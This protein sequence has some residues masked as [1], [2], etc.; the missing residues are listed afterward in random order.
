MMND[1]APQKRSN[2]DE[3]Y[4]IIL[5]NPTPEQLIQAGFS[6][7]A[8]LSEHFCKEQGAAYKDIP[9]TNIVF[10]Q[11]KEFKQFLAENENLYKEGDDR[12]QFAK[13][14]AEKFLNEQLKDYAGKNNYLE[15]N[16]LRCHQGAFID[17]AHEFLSRG[18]PLNMFNPTTHYLRLDIDKNIQST[19]VIVDAKTI[20]ANDKQ[21]SC[22]DMGLIQSIDGSPL[23]RI[24][25]T[26]QTNL[27][28]KSEKTTLLEINILNEEIK[29]L[30]FQHIEFGTDRITLENIIKQHISLEDNEHLKIVITEANKLFSIY[31]DGNDTQE[32]HQS[33]YLKMIL[34]ALKEHTFSDDKNNLIVSSIINSLHD[35]IANKKINT[36]T[37]AQLYEY[38]I[39]LNIQTVLT[40]DELAKYEKLYNDEKKSTTQEKITAVLSSCYSWF[41]IYGF[42]KITNNE[43]VTNLINS[44]TDKY[45]PQGE[46]EIQKSINEKYH[47][48]KL[49]VENFIA[50]NKG[51]NSV[52]EREVAKLVNF[53]ANRLEQDIDELKFRKQS[54]L[55]KK[56]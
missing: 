37:N 34:I 55:T 46:T 43:L 9:R 18:R 26:F 45:E 19:T 27:A 32:N 35:A 53:L 13:D 36:L 33:N 31:N 8:D 6:N 7:L 1:A 56:I 30:Y 23:V 39:S 3:I 54:S 20:N 48:K 5:E 29:N 42:F 2:T 10:I 49:L 38:Q 44:L 40:N 24:T 50:L 17:I 12:S 51:E 28:E 25:S 47:M 21:N 11:G 22:D 52:H 41:S 16:Q 14:M 4:S 15:Y